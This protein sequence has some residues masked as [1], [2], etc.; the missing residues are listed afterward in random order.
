MMVLQLVLGF[1]LGAVT[2]ALAWRFNALSF[3]GAL[4]AA[5]VGTLVFGFGGLPMALGLLTFFVSSSALSRAFR[6]RKRTLRGIYAKGDRRDWGQVLANGGLAAGLAVFGAG[7]PGEVWPQLAFAGAVAS[8][9]ADTW[10]TELGVLSRRPPRLVTTGR[11]VPRGTSG[12]VTVLGTLAAVMGA[13]LIGAVSAPFIKPA[14]LPGVLGLVA[15]AGLAGSLIDSLLGATLQGVYTCPRCEKQ[16]E[17]HPIH[18]CGSPTDHRRGWE[19]LN[20]DLVNLAASAAGAIL[21]AGVGW[22]IGL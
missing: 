1:V 8:V 18:H 4:A 9:T 15:A 7:L 19:W 14:N 17:Q 10:S 16:T 6:E 3:N 20:N 2:S 5:A 11:V 22:A 13:L 21:A 12:G